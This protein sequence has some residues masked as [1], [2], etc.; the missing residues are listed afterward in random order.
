[1][2]ARNGITET[3]IA[4]ALETARSIITEAT[5]EGDRLHRELDSAWL[6]IL[7]RT[8]RLLNGV[9]HA[10]SLASPHLQLAQRRLHLSHAVRDL[11]DAVDFRLLSA[12]SK[13]QEFDVK[14]SE[15]DPHTALARAKLQVT[16]IGSELAT[17]PTTALSKA[18]SAFRNSRTRLLE[19]SPKTKV[20]RLRFSLDSWSQSL[21]EALSETV[22]TFRHDLAMASQSLKDLSPFGVLERGYALVEDSEGRVVSDYQSVTSGDEVTV[23]LAKGRLDCLVRHAENKPIPE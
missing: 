4:D 20:M 19:L 12:K 2:K 3:G 22:R 15:V 16:E 10:L 23:Q 13:L 8:Q 7:H 17:A 18:N 21:N 14:L 6:Q 11:D 9:S 1:M 5:L